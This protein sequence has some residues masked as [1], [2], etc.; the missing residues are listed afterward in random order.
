MAAS[1]GVF[2]RARP[3][4]GPHVDR[5][6]EGPGIGTFHFFPAAPR[7]AAPLPLRRSASSSCPGHTPSPPCR[8]RSCRA[9]ASRCAA[10]AEHAQRCE[11]ALAQRA[12]CG[13]RRARRGG[14]RL[15]CVPCRSRTAA[16]RNVRA[17]CVAKPAFRVVR[18]CA[19]RRA[20]PSATSGR[21]PRRRHAHRRLQH[22]HAQR[23]G[24]AP[25]RG[26]AARSDSVLLVSRPGGAARRCVTIPAA[27]RWARLR[28]ARA[29]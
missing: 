8:T 24:D 3:S 14:R 27:A 9:A 17:A 23:A 4:T 19:P 29:R 7:R 5:H 18:P 10:A 2:A 13:R 1:R 28:A 12:P 15:S 6:N 26:G 22:R 20:E 11:A 21:S 25:R 16:P